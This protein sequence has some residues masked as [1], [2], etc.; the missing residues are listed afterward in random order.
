MTVSLA[1]N[2]AVLR[3]V[4]VFLES[5]G[6]ALMQADDVVLL[7]N[8]VTVHGAESRCET[9]HGRHVEDGGIL[10]AVVWLARESG[11]HLSV[12]DAWAAVGFFALAGRTTNGYWERGDILKIQDAGSE[13]QSQNPWIQPRG[14]FPCFAISI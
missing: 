1:Q 14:A 9:A 8:F 7:S 4:E 10:D 11:A 6:F 12:D 5:G 2:F 13:K 3:G